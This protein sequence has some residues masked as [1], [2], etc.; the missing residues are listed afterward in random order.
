MSLSYVSILSLWF[1]NKNFN[2]FIAL[3]EVKFDFFYDSIFFS[4]GIT[5]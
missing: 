5:F 4:K 3:S 1:Y 2:H